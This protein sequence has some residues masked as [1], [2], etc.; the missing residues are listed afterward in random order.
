MIKPGLYPERSLLGA[1]VK[2]I[3]SPAF[4]LFGESGNEKIY[5]IQS[6]E[7]RVDMDGQFR[8]GITLSGL[9]NRRYSPEDLCILEIPECFTNKKDENG[10][11]SQEN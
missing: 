3:S 1:K 6:F 9:P 10:K 5:Q 8:L 2:I 4:E 11:E 7:Y